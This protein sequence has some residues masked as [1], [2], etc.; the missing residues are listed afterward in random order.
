MFKDL[1]NLQ[2]NE[3]AQLL[4]EEKNCA[5]CEFA[6]RIDRIDLLCCANITAIEEG[7]P[8]VSD[9]VDNAVKPNYRCLNFKSDVN[10]T[11][12]IY[13]RKY[14][15]SSIKISSDDIGV[16]KDMIRVALWEKNEK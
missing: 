8:K 5:W 13:G 2:P 4:L 7:L 14:F 10:G 1:D 6:F 11:D 12:N 16:T 3:M 9:E 15:N